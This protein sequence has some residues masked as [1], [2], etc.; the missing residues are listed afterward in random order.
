MASIIANLS[1]PILINGAKPSLKPTSNFP[2]VAFP[3]EFL[4]YIL[5]LFPDMN[6]SMYL[7]IWVN[8][9]IRVITENW[10]LLDEHLAFYLDK[11]LYPNCLLVM[12]TP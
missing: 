5:F 1:L 3:G 10:E 2:V 11:K 12:I 7:A 9:W 6:Y 8:F 4:I